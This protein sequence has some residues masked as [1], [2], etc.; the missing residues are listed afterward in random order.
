MMTI[1]D[2]LKKLEH[3]LRITKRRN[4]SSDSLEVK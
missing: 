2:R 4:L 1:E 3:E